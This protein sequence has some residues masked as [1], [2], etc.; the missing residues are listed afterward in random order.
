M[1]KQDTESCKQEYIR[2]GIEMKITAEAPFMFSH[3][4]LHGDFCSATKTVMH[5][6]SMDSDM[7]DHFTKMN[8]NQSG[9]SKYSLTV[10][11]K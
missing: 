1:Y 3:H 10:L 9:R 11:S 2:G 7:H 8:D 4:Q 5:N 6:M